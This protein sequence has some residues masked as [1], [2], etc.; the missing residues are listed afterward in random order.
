MP[1]SCVML[2]EH[3]TTEGH[4]F[5]VL[6]EANSQYLFCYITEKK[7]ELPHSAVSLT[8]IF[9]LVNHNFE[10]HVFQFFANDYIIFAFLNSLNTK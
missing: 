4:I 10:K 8:G 2:P 1:R 6:I 5:S 3:C 7:K 9:K